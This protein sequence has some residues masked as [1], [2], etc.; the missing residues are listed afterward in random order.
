MGR[1]DGKVAIISGGARGQGAAEA[2]LFAQEG[3][4]V[5]VTDVLDALGKETAASIGAQATYHH[6]DVRIEDEWGSVVDAVLAEHGQIDVLINNAGI[7]RVGPLV[8]TTEEEYRQ[9]IDINQVGV[10]LGMKAV[11]P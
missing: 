5:V 9:V 1:L 11:V 4:A 10:F 2:T 8:M 7:F 3:A 6:H